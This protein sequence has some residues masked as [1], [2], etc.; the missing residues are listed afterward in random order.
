MK[1]IIF[2]SFCWFHMTVFSQARE[3]LKVI[4]SDKLNTSAKRM[5]PLV[6]A[7]LYATYAGIGIL[8]YTYLDDE[9][10]ENILLRTDKNLSSLSH[11]IGYAG[12]GVTQVAIVVATG[13]TS[14]IEKNNRLKKATILLIGSHLFN[15]FVTN[16][17]KI[18]FE[19]HRPNTSDPPHSFDWRGGS[20]KN[21]S[22]ISAHT[23]NAF[24]TAAV[25][26]LCFPEKKWVGIVGYTLATLVGLSRVYDNQHWMT[27]V[28]AGAVVGCSSAW[29]MN[30][31][32]TLG[33]H[34][35]S[36]LPNVNNGHYGI[37]MICSL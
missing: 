6:K 33:A 13:I 4:N 35:F 8:S 14:I 36:F 29:I 10:R 7:A 24:C 1:V 28:M 23:S 31:L 9:I 21:Q 2:I 37:G 20:R 15:D 19:R 32:Y 17:A 16:Q 26:Q 3:N 11:F 27:D 25:F 34:R 5:K 30:K 12:L 18:T 22:F